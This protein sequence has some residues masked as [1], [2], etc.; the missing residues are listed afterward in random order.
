MHFTLPSI[1]EAFGLAYLEAMASGLPVVAT[2]D[3]MRRLYCCR[4][5]YTM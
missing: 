5:W 1:D 4:W 3:E 2:D